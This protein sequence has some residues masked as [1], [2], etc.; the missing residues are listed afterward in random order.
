MRIAM[1]SEHASPLPTGE[2]GAGAQQRHVADL[3]AALAQLGHDVRV[4]TR[5]DDPELP[6]VAKTGAG[7]RVVHVPAGPAQ[8]LPS[9]QPLAHMGDFARW[10]RAD[11]PAVGPRRRRWMVLRSLWRLRSLDFLRPFPYCSPAAARDNACWRGAA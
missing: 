9:E 3:S 2:A 5:R 8:V 1:I 11:E 10:L 7:V 4:Y 6:A